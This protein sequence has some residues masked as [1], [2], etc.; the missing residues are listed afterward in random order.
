LPKQLRFGDT[1]LSHKSVEE[2]KSMGP[3]AGLTVI[4]GLG[5]IV[6]GCARA[7]L[8]APANATPVQSSPVASP[9]PEDRLIVISVGVDPILPESEGKIRVGL[10][11]YARLFYIT[12]SDPNFEKLL[13]LLKDA[14]DHK[15][16][17]KCTVREHSG[18]IEQV[19]LEE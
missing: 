14:M 15:K 4:V 17:V 9:T 6:M 5:V 7:K 1:Q 11:P 13:A 12:R 10:L 19:V 16:L 3:Y 8:P 2:V 18:R